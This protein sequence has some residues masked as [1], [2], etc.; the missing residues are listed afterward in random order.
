MPFYHTEIS[1]TRFTS[2]Q[3]GLATF[4]KYP[5]I[6]QGLIQQERKSTNLAMFTDFRT[7]TGDTI[8]VYNC[9]LQS[10]RF[11]SDDYDFMENPSKS[12]DTFSKVNKAFSLLKLIKRAYS[13]RTEQADAIA[14]HI[15]STELPK[16]VCGDFNDPPISYTY[17][18]LS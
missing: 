8:R 16:V 2:D 1:I 14:E 3:Y 11:K 17:K 13:Y 5:I 9:H 7:S 10:I 15:A 12:A 4:S 6:D 18:T